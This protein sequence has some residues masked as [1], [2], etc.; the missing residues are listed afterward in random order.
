MPAV[1][2]VCSLALRDTVPSPSLATF[3]PL[4]AVG[5]LAYECQRTETLAR[6]LRSTPLALVAAL[7][8]LAA[9][10]LVG[11]P[12]GWALPFYALFFVAIACGNP[13]G[14]LLQARG[15]LVLGECSYGIYIL[16]GIA[17]SI[18]FVDAAPAL[19]RVPTAWLLLLLPVVAGVVVAAAAV[20][21]LGVERPMMRVGAR[22]ARRWTGRPI[23]AT[24]PGVE[25]AP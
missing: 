23:P 8:L 12:F 3:L 24:S 19:Q 9:M 14:G 13:M 2:L 21:H 6:L 15:V 11:T 10:L 5:M 18:L 25:V 20:T 22:L 17:L 16:H 7:G 1:L 4:F